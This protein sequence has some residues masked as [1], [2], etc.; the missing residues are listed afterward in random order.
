MLHLHINS[1]VCWLK[2]GSSIGCVLSLVMMYFSQRDV[3]LCCFGLVHLLHKCIPSTPPPHTQ[4]PHTHTHPHTDTG[5]EHCIFSIRNHWFVKL[6][7]ILELLF[8]LF[9][10]HLKHKRQ[11]QQQQQT[12][13]YCDPDTGCTIRYRICGWNIIRHTVFRI[14][15]APYRTKCPGDNSFGTHVLMTQKQ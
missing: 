15:W 3:T 13:F 6:S 14:S 9:K 12:D 1:L 5:T 4:H 8:W 11:R 2:P 10:N 7:F